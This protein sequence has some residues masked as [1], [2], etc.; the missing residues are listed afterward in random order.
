MTSRSRFR[1]IVALAAAIGVRPAF[2]EIP[3][4]IAATGHPIIPVQIAGRS[5][6][7]FVLD[8]GADQTVL[9]RHY[10]D[11]LK[12]PL[13]A[14][15]E[16]IGQTG[17]AQV[18]GVEIPPFVIDGRGFP[19]LSS[20]ALPDRADGA[21]LNGIVGLDVMR[22][23]IAEIDFARG[24]FALSAKAEGSIAAEPRPGVKIAARRLPAGHLAF[25]VKVNGVP[26]VAVLD[27]GAR[28]TRL[29]WLFARAAGYSPDDQSLPDAGAIQ[30][31]TNTALQSKSIEIR[32]LEVPGQT[33]ESLKARAIDLPVFAQFG[34]ADGPALIL[35]FD[36]LRRAR[37]TLDVDADE[38][39]FDWPVAVQAR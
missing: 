37:L 16:L 8:T 11:E 1:L 7:T 6:V 10:A 14:G 2:A 25:D 26:G 17:A 13:G 28:D 5:A 12:L 18:P 22:G 9:Y 38:I 39:W 24:R 32:A 29:N 27:S 31:A 15:E 33:I 36:V 3:I 20:V 35:G 19:A 23:A 4:T 21:R 30:G 34:V